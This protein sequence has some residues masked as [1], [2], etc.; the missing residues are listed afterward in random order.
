MT[1]KV[2]AVLIVLMT[3]SSFFSSADSELFKAARSGNDSKILEL[4]AQGSNIDERDKLEWTPLF[5]AISWGKIDTAKLLIENNSSINLVN[6]EGN[7]PLHM[8]AFLGHTELVR[9]L[10]EKGADIEA[11]NNNA[12]TALFY[13]SAGKYEIT[14]FL[15]KQGAKQTA[16]KF[17]NTPI[18]H[19]TSDETKALLKSYQK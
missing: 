17:G 14:E 2:K 13:A 15:L 12:Q 18:K 11:K 7:T 5:E 6:N 4:L 9:L 1:F 8:A 19:T 3:I 10:V 16:D